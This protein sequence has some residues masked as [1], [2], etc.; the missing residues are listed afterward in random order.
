MAMVAP[1]VAFITLATA[2]G[3]I[4]ADAFFVGTGKV[5]EAR[6]Q[7]VDRDAERAGTGVEL[8][9]LSYASPQVDVVLRNT[10]RVGLRDFPSWDVWVDYYEADGT[11][12]TE[13]LSYTSA[14]T[15]RRISGALRAST[16]TR[17][18]GR[19]KP[20]NRASSTPVKR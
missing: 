4:V 12:H 16:W 20:G 3:L 7:A 17:P 18:R 9:T 10:G 13:R 8:V 6:L 1:F 19:A 15:P 5:L 11:H 2:A 14:A